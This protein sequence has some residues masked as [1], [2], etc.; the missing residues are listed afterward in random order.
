MAAPRSRPA[1]REEGAPPRERRAARVR[2]DI[3]VDVRC[4]G[5]ADRAAAAL[6]DC[7]GSARGV[8]TEPPCSIAARVIRL[9]WSRAASGLRRDDLL[10]EVELTARANL[11]P[12]SSAS[13][14]F[15]SGTEQSPRVATGGRS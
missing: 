5:F 8:D 3:T 12:A 14:G 2:Q 15:W 10:E 4:P 9:H 6:Q 7:R 1:K 11:P 13:A